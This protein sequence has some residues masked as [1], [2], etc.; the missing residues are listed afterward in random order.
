MMLT[1]EELI[2]RS[3]DTGQYALDLF[4]GMLAYAQSDPEWSGLSA[5]EKLRRT[6]PIAD[7]VTNKHLAKCEVNLRRLIEEQTGRELCP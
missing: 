7:R 4:K 3:G 6:K 2:R 5:E 1:K